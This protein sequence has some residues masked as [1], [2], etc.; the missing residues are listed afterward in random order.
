MF[1]DTAHMLVFFMGPAGLFQ[2]ATH[3]PRC[4][5]H[6][7]CIIDTPPLIGNGHSLFAKEQ[8]GDT[9]M[10]PVNICRPVRRDLDL[11]LAIPMRAT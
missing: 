1:R 6:P 9:R 3:I 2:D 10:D 8:E 7:H 5:C 4:P 11:E